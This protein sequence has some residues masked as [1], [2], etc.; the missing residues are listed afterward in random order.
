MQGRVIPCLALALSLGPQGALAAE[1]S[2]G[3]GQVNFGTINSF[4]PETM[5]TVGT[6]VVVC[7]ES[8]AWVQV[9]FSSGNT[10]H[11]GRRELRSGQH[12]L[13]YNLYS[14]ANQQRILGDGSPGASG[15][16]L[17]PS[18]KG[19]AIHVPIFAAIDPGQVLNVGTYTDQIIVTIDF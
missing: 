7:D 9:R 16:E 2:V 6:L 11:A 1:C 14:D 4:R 5:Q 8:V 10:G 19:Q 12:A 3:G 17:S 15:L 13:G 18:V